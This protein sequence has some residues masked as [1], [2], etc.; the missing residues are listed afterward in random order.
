MLKACRV[1]LVLFLFAASSWGQVFTGSL[2]GTRPQSSGDAAS[3]GVFLVELTGNTVTYAI[4]YFGSQSPTAAHIHQG[5]AGQTGSIVVDLAPSFTALGGGFAATGT[6]TATPDVA[7]AIRANPA[8]YYVNVHTSAFP[9]GAAR[10]QLASEASGVEH[11]VTM[12]SGARERPTVGDPDGNGVALVVPR[13]DQALYYLRVSNTQP[14]TGAH[15]HR[16]K[17][18]EAGSIVLSLSPTFNNGV[19]VG[20]VSLSATLAGEIRTNPEGFYVNVHTADFPGGAVRGQL[21]TGESVVHVPVAADV[22]GLPPSLFRTAGTVTNFSDA[23]AEVW[24][25]WYPSSREARSAPAKVQR[26]AVPARGTAVFNNL[27]SELFAASGRG[28]VRFYSPAKIAVAVN[29]FNDQRPSGGTFGQFAQGLAVSEALTRGVLPYNRHQAKTTGSGWRT[30][31]GWFNPSPQAVTLQVQVVRPDGT[32]AG[33]KTVTLQPWSNDLLACGDGN[34]YVPSAACSDNNFTVA[35]TA[36]SPVFLYSSV[37]DNVTD[38]GLYQPA[39]TAP[40]EFVNPPAPGN[41]PP[42]VTITSPASDITV[43]V[44]QNVSFTATASDPDGDTLTVLWNFGDGV[45]D[46]TNSLSVSHAY[47]T[48]GTYTATV[49]VSD[50]KGGQAQASR[51]VTVQ[52]SGGYTLSQLQTDIFTPRCSGCHPPTEGLDLSPGQTYGSTVNVP[53]SEMP[54][55]MRVKP[56]DPDNSYLY[57]KI[58]GVGISGARMP[59][60][61]PYLSQ[62]EIDKVKGWIEAGAPNN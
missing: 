59:Q 8:G 39:Q 17:A 60:G 61:G 2:L 9:G 13:S 10:A 41:N 19:A 14:P 45:T 20:A 12:L 25:E 33:S 62:S 38:D 48:A 3:S 24:A 5:T 36:S 22:P 51:Q 40:E 53:S 15:I 43:Q 50:G 31:F 44:G 6:V 37:V 18:G 57:R 42:T 29:I 52:A 16:G 35:F 49:S 1:V 34:G 30:N 46:S 28:A 21:T 11:W 4:F 54:S 47:A 56:G 23:E 32:T 7:S 26:F 55:L 58:R 27:V